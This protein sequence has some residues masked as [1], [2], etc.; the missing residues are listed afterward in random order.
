VPVGR[1]SWTLSLSD[2]PLVV[3]LFVLAP[4]PFLVARLAG[5]AVPL[6]VRHR[7]SPH[8]LVFNLAW[9]S[10]EASLALLVWHGVQAAGHELGSLTW[11]ASAAVTVATD[12]AGT[13]L[14]GLAIAADSDSRFA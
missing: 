12:L 6:A 11:V 13:V 1:N 9:Y 10:V 2:V 5:A 7:G 8:K 4:V 3:G 14:I